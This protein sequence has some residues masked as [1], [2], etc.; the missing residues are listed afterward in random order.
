MATIKQKKVVDKLLENNG[1]MSKTMR[2]VGYSKNFSKNPQTLA[3][4]KGFK[5]EVAPIIEQLEKE[6]QRLI[7]A[8][9]IMDLDE[10]EYAEAVRS[11]D[12]LT[13]N[14]Q[15]LSDK[16]TENVKTNIT[17]EQIDE[18]LRRRQKNNEGR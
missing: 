12:L 18:L 11:M 8:I 14:I 3:K 13:K 15:L 1:N 6:R 16:P 7:N 17:K 4:S 5:K 9:T 10:I 2:Q